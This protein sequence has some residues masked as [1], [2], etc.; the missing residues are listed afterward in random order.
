[1]LTFPVLLSGLDQRFFDVMMLLV[2]DLARR[3]IGSEPLA[4]TAP[5]I[6]R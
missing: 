1:V 4:A 5:P 3:M 2:P 6:D